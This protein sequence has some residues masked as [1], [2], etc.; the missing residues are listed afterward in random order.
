VNRKYITL[1]SFLLFLISFFVSSLSFA[2]GLSIKDIVV[3]GEKN[4]VRLSSVLKGDI[5]DDIT[6]TIKSGIPITF[7]YYVELHRKKAVWVDTMVLSKTI[8][9]TVNY[10]NLK[11]EYKL[12]QAVDKEIKDSI[13]KD[14][15]EVKQWMRKL[16]KVKIA[17]YNELE[18][19]KTYY[20]KVKAELK[21]IKF[22]FPLNYVL[23]FFSF[24][25][26][27][28]SW[29]NSPLFVIKKSLKKQ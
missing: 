2:E 14:I 24:F 3:S 27:D 8:K 15:Q 22:I 4:E 29:H 9:N 1:L 11:K 6:E 21:S 20:I 7:T 26:E 23:F 25:D 5:D 13:S 19:D 28:T 16:D 17:G 18:Y 10:D 12:T